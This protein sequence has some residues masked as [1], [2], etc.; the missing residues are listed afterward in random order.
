MVV[1]GCEPVGCGWAGAN[2]E[3]VVVLDGVHARP[4]EL[5]DDRPDAVGLLA[6]DACRTGMRTRTNEGCLSSAEETPPP[7][8]L[9]VHD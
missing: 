2:G 9:L 7:M 8:R 3:A 6:T 4:S 1:I 5:G